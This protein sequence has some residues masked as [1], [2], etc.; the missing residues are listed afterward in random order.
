MEEAAEEGVGSGWV[1]AWREEWGVVPAARDESTRDIEK[2]K[3]KKKI[4]VRKK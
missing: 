4:L 1:G 3:K 2:K